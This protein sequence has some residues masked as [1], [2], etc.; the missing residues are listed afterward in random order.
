MQWQNIFWKWDIFL[1]IPYF[2]K[3]FK[4]TCIVFCLVVKSNEDNNN[5]NKT[6]YCRLLNYKELWGQHQEEDQEKWKAVS[7]IVVRK[8][9]RKRWCVHCNLPGFEE[10]WAHQQ[11]KDQED[12][13]VSIIVFLVVKS[14]EHSNNKKQIRLGK[15]WCVRRCLRGCEELWGVV[16]ITTTRKPQRRWHTLSFSWL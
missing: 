1:Q 7:T 4:P 11:E 6:A 13:E 16:S 3:T 10:V 5:N 2:C 9:L 12:D 15:Q 14:C 8:K